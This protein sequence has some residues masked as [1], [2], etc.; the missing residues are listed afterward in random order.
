MK[1]PAVRSDVGYVKFEGGMDLASPA[2]SI[3]AG[4]A[5]DGMNYEA[6]VTGVFGG[7]RRIDGFERYSGKPSPSDAFYWYASAILSGTPVVGD[8]ITG[9]SSAA[10]GVIARI[11]GS[12][13]SLTKITGAFVAEAFTGGGGGTL[14]VAPTRG[15]YSAGVDDATSLNAAADIYRADIGTVNG[16]RPI[17]GGWTYKGVQYAFVDNAGGTACE[18]FKS[19]S[20]GWT[21]VALGRKLAFTSGGT[22]V[23][24]EGDTI[25][26]ELSGA[27]AVLTR[28]PLET[29]TYA[30]GDATG[31]YIFASQTGTFQVETVK[32]GATLNVANV[33]GN[34]T[35]ITLAPAGRYEFVNYNFYG[36]TDTLRMYGCDGV[37]KSFEFDGATFV[38]INTGMA[39]DRPLHISAHKKM[40][41]LSFYGSTQ[42]S[43]VG[44]PY[45][46]IAALGATEIG[47]GDS[48]TG[49]LVQPGDTL[50][51]FARNSTHQLIGSS[52][53]DF[54]LKPL[55][56][57]TGGIP[58]TTQNLGNRAYAL[59]D[60]G[61]IE[62]TRTQAFGNFDSATVSRKVQSLINTMRSVVVASSVYKSRNQYRLYASNGTGLVMTTDGDIVTGL[63]PF[64]YN[65]GRTDN[66]INPTCAWNGEDSTGKDVVFFGA[67][68]GY[69]YQADKG[70]SFDG[71]EI[72]A[73]LRMPFNNLKSPRHNK[74]YFKAVLEMTSVSYAEIRFQPEF[75]YGDSD[76]QGHAIAAS[77]VQ[78]TGGYWDVAQ[79]DT[80]FY[81]ARSVNSP[82][83]DINGSGSNMSL[84]F[85]SFNDLDLGH[86]LQG[87]LIHYILRSLA[88]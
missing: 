58:Y 79:W 66:L 74:E 62:L 54:V 28:I 32:V 13:L 24:A 19:S 6:G 20:S 80:F 16:A 23:P 45:K 49:Y 30:A 77:A 47:I 64:D 35:A 41:Q 8:T 75:S 4:C 34:S 60:R 86:T 63:M 3:T 12:A 65:S 59:D 87:V 72:Q 53:N 1:L 44:T 15:G 46:W 37:N 78:G 56:P 88:R 70:S 83:F 51:I 26:G 10:T 50:A 27:T 36:S 71:Y 29:G 33:A 39:L 21:A 18:M 17:R 11:D 5:A 42:T 52:T 67:D 85:Y 55:S 57:E 40:L 48:V 68:N 25:T 76:I 61:I 43:G 7:F 84:L 38:Q 81:D 73:Y 14:T 2:L 31:Q 82:E 9:V 69:V 22:Y